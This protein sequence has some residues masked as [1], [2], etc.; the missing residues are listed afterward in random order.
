MTKRKAEL[1]AASLFDFLRLG[2]ETKSVPHP[3][4]SPPRRRARLETMDQKSLF[5]NETKRVPHPDPS[6]PRRRARR[7]ATPLQKSPPVELF[8]DEGRRQVGTEPDD[9]W[10]FI[11]G[12]VESPCDPCL[13]DLSPAASNLPA[14]SPVPGGGSRPLIAQSSP[15]TTPCAKSPNTS[16]KSP[17]DAIVPYTRRRLVGK[18]PPQITLTIEVYTSRRLRGK[19]PP[20]NVPERKTISVRGHYDVLGIER[21]ANAAEVHAAYRRRALATHPDKGGD[22]R[23]F[24]RVKTAFEELSNEAKRAAYDRSLVFFGRKDG[25]PEEPVKSSQNIVQKTSGLDSY[26]GAA[27]IA[28]FSLLAGDWDDWSATLATMQDEV[29]KRLRDILKGIKS[30]GATAM[31]ADSD[32]QGILQGW[33]GP[34]CITQRKSGYKVTVCWEEL[35]ICSGFT[36]SLTQV[37]DWQIAL[38]SMQ[39][40]AK[41]RM[42][43]RGAGSR[44]PLTEN[45]LLQVLEREPDL[46]L[47]FT[48][49]VSYGGKKGKKISSP[50]VL[51]LHTAMEFYH[52]FK[53]AS[54][55]KNCEAALKSEK[56]KAEQE[57]AQEN[58]KRKLCER[59]LL[60]AVD[61]ELQA[62][63]T[64]RSTGTHDASSKA[65]VL[66]RASQ[67]DNV[68]TTPTPK[69][70]SRAKTSPCKSTRQRRTLIEAPAR[71]LRA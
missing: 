64:G 26:F 8:G 57:A 33:N 35:S 69:E 14:A 18:Q 21:T 68:K 58:K 63:R 13:F 65:L 67:Q 12:K 50:G 10:D 38:L 32:A 56:R 2:N 39:S 36:K 40:A 43:R 3:D 19:Q 7:P 31:A 4:P 55:G 46:E 22:P 27:R 20:P 11:W 29:L 6:P 16:V 30:K 23:D 52:R 41:L 37:I 44:D 28:H 49:T 17:K 42:K 71:K 47:L 62:R 34:T 9:L 59:R 51:N 54:R 53:A 45:E 25:T 48:V 1:K 60:V 15:S 24:H 5:G 61:E 70:K 66:H